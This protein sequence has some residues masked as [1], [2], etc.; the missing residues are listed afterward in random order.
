MF[1]VLLQ[2]IIPHHLLSRIMFRFLRLRWHHLK[3]LQI[4]FFIDRFKVDMSQADNPDIESFEHFNAFFTRSLKVDVRPINQPDDS[5]SYC[6]PVD[7]TISQFGRITDQKLIQAKG[8]DY[9]MPELVG[10]RHDTAERFRNGC[11]ATFYL[12]PRDYH[13]I[14]MPAS[15]RLKSMT[16]VPGR[17]FS[18]ASRMAQNLPGLFNR[19]ERVICLFETDNG[20][21]AIVLVGALFVGCM[22]TVWHGTVTPPH[23]LSVRHTEYDSDE[24]P[25]LDK[26]KEMGRF[27]MGSTVIVLW[28]R[29]NMQWNDELVVGQSIR[30]GSNISYAE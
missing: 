18:V 5:H 21:M 17:L 12:S 30:M 27:N 15:G 23:D 24:A 8:M 14:H 25:Y 29:Q 11:F 10:A 9:S 4:R 26:G 16:C 2:T 28:S 22:D 19:N 1:S 3:N 20:A 13:R 7:G 6:S